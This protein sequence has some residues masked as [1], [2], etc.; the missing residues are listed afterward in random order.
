M[1]DYRTRPD[2]K[3][4]IPPA[5]IVTHHPAHEFFAGLPILLAQFDRVLIVDNAS[6]EETRLMLR[7]A[8]AQFEAQHLTILFNFENRGIASALNQ[9]FRWALDQGYEHL[10]V[11]DQDSRPASNMT[12]ELLQVYEAHPRR[13]R[14]AIIAPRI[15]DELTGE[16]APVVRWHG[17]QLRKD[18]PRADVLENV[19][20]VITSG[21]L[22]NLSIYKKLGPFRDDFFIDYVDTEYCLRARAN[23]FEIVLASQAVLYHRLGDQRMK[24]ISKLTLRPTFHSPRRWYY[25]HRNRIR[26]AGMYFLRFPNWVIY[27]LFVGI[28]AFLKMLAYEDHKLQKIWAVFLGVFDGITNRMGP[29]SARRTA[30]LEPHE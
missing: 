26:M 2:P 27:D 10:F 15:V 17:F 11:L 20:L 13:E 9:G 29:I 12:R 23:G 16:T 28:Y 3:M 1:N 21:S 25:M 14:I 22:N 18:V 8:A 30:Q 24:H 7:Q 19:A 6:A 5:L 4:Y